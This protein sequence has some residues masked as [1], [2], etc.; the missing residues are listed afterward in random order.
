MA[1]IAEKIGHGRHRRSREC[2]VRRPI[3]HVLREWK[4]AKPGRRVSATCRSTCRARSSTPPTCCRSASSGGGDQLEV[5]HGDAYY[6]SYICRIPRSTV[7][8]GVSGR[9]DFIDAML[10]PSICDVIRNLSG[11]WKLMFPAGLHSLF[12]RAAEL[13]ATRS[14]ATYYVNELAELRH[15]L[16]VLRGKPVTDD[17]LNLSIAAYNENRR[18]VQRTLRAT[19]SRKSRGRFRPRKCISLMRAGI[20]LTVEHTRRCCATTSPPPALERA[21]AAR[22]LPRRCHR[23]VLRAAAAQPHQIARAGRLLCSRR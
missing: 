17:E 15:D 12:R 9:L 23:R 3:L 22:Q 10:F 14:A 2:T 5:V 8:L 1:R 21:S 7:E 11:M 19:V 13:P 16:G 20:I 18:L 4:A 6:Q